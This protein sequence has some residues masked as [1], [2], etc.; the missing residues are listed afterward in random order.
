MF[1]T[2]SRYYV[3]RPVVPQ[4][5]VDAVVVVRRVGRLAVKEGLGVLECDT[6]RVF[7]YS[8]DGGDIARHSGILEP[9][10]QR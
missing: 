2:R 1:A 4:A 3:C 9:E 7:C 5:R 8:L 10:M 6:C